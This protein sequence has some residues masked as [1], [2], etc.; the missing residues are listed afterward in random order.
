[1]CYCSTQVISYCTIQCNYIIDNQWRHTQK[2]YTSHPKID[3]RL[4][5]KLGIYTAPPLTKF[6]KKEIHTIQSSR[7]F[8][9]IFAFL[10][11]LV[12]IRIYELFGTLIGKFSVGI[13]QS[14]LSSAQKSPRP[15]KLC[16]GLTQGRNKAGLDQKENNKDR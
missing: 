8:D 11:I 10:C 12:F 4:V 6:K 2:I 14:F 7:A 13:N 1:M 5:D 15:I 3:K 9:N 16:F